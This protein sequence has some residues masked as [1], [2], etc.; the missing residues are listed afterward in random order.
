MTEGKEGGWLSLTEEVPDILWLKIKDLSPEMSLK[1]ILEKIK[2][3]LFLIYDG[4]K[5]KGISFSDSRF[6][7][8]SEMIERGM[9]SC[10]AMSN[11]F[12]VV[13]RKYGIAVRFIH[14]ILSGQDHEGTH[15]HAW[16]EIY[17][18][19][20]DSWIEIDPTTRNFEKRDDAIRRKV[21][22]DWLELKP[23]Y[24]KGQY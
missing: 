22:H 7:P 21:Y 18:P 23:D 15:R 20:S 2:K 24:E 9:V 4:K 11:I 13:L 17:N 10:G 12:G 19:T 3:E 6:T 14:G 5:D 1:M 16:L 8:I